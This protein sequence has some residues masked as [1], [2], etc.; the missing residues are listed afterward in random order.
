MTNRN[1]RRTLHRAT[2]ALLTLAAGTVFEGSCAAGWEIFRG[3]AAGPI[4][5]GIKQILDGVVDGVVT[6]VDPTDSQSQSGTSS[7]SSSSSST[8]N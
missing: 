2:L 8:T 1:A 7:S 6:V 5:A 4:G 3:E